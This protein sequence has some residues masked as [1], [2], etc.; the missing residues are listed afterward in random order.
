MPDTGSETPV[1]LHVWSSEGSAVLDEDHTMEPKIPES[2]SEQVK[3][4]NHVSDVCDISW[5]VQHGSLTYCS[6]RRGS[7]GR[8]SGFNYKML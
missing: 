8:G 6:N 5:L 2:I 4:D 1:L 3:M 7:G